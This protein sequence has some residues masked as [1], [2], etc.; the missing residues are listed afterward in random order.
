MTE[1]SVWTTINVLTL[2]LVAGGA[3]ALIALAVSALR[4]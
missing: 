4:R 3:V 1:V 2:L